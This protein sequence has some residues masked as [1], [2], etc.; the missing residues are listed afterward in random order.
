MS[1]VFKASLILT[2]FFGVNKIVALF[3]QALIARQ[4]GITPDIDAFN[5]SNNIPDLIFSIISGGA[6]SLA[7]I[8]VLTEYFDKKGQR[9][10][11]KLFSQI[12]NLVFFSTAIL[13]LLVI[14]FAP[15]IIGST[16]GVAPGFSSQQKILTANL[17]QINLIA[18]LIFSLSG[19]IM[20]ALQSKKHFLLPAIAPI[21]YN[22][23]QIIG[24]IILTP[25]FHLGVYGLAYGVVLGAFLHMA[26]QIPAM[27]HFKFRY[28]PSLGLKDPSV[29]KVIRL[30]GPRI[31]TVFVIQIM[32]LAR[33]NLASHLSAGSV[34]ALTY[35]Y[36]IMQVP[37][38]LI[39][40]SIATA[41]LPTLSQFAERK[42]MQAFTE[43]LN[44]TLRVITS[45][46]LVI[47]VLSL[48]SLDYA[49]QIIFNF[50]KANTLLLSSVTKVFLIGLLFQ[51]LLE[52]TMRT[53]YA[54]QDTKTPFVI[55]LIRAVFYIVLS[56]IL[57]KSEGASGLAW[58]DTITTTLTV[59]VMLV[60]MKKT[61][62]GLLDM[63]GTLKRTAVACISCIGV[64][65]IVFS[66]LHFP[67]LVALTLFLV[68][69]ATISVVTL[70]NEI[71][72]LL[73][74]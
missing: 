9:D 43:T 58:A 26:V 8:P 39:G 33:D 68:I 25:F 46:T 70:K 2:L 4:F 34:S 55:T 62:P 64:F 57:M 16:L 63:K 5:V 3:R 52:I 14:V 23:G 60:L 69:S 73:K 20:A 6:L 45:S 30:M 65:Y 61:L 67:L 24:A 22:V 42:N 40:T 19:L 29:K 36:F 10:A 74:I 49:V 56:I 32:F 53:F 51:C 31:L 47:T 21:L 17:M 28:T 27:I 7:F 54:R 11:W 48:V 38:T 13:S 18:T 37:E 35:G 12:A 59:I 50:N 66:L 41:L 44:K 71:K 15:T 72:L 1:Q